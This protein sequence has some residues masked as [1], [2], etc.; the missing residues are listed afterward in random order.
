[1]HLT[2]QLADSQSIDTQV[3]V[4][5]SCECSTNDSLNNANNCQT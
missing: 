2:K 4:T 5:D 1:V 3:V